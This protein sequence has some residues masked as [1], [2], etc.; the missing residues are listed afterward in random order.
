[1]QQK[2]NKEEKWKENTNRVKWDFFL[3]AAFKAH[4]I[5]F[6]KSLSNVKKNSI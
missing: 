2:E 6:N 4:F 5:Y 3:F 1:M